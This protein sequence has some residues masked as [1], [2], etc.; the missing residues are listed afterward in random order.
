MS[1]EMSMDVLFAMGVMEAVVTFEVLLEQRDPR[2]LGT[3]RDR[4]R[5][6]R[7][8]AATSEEEAEAEGET[9]DRRSHRG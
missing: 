2:D 8:A 3:R 9:D 1:A 6:V 4:G 7:R 5:G